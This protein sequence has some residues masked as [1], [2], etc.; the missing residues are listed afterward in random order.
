[1][2]RFEISGTDIFASGLQDMLNDLPQLRDDILKAE[3]DVIEQ[4]MGQSITSSG[5][6]RSGV[7]RQ[8]IRQRKRKDSIAIGPDGEHHRYTP[9]GKRSGANGIVTA[10]YVGYI[11]N[12]GIPRRGIPAREWAEKAVEKGQ[13]PAMDA[14]EKVY[15]EFLKK[16]D[17]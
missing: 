13:G 2:A 4:Y 15:D 7:L 12:Y 9:S 17:L 16:Q 11:H 6:V 3:A 5:L 10:G 1:M 8:S 14:A